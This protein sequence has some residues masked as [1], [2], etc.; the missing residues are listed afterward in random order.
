MEAKEFKKRISQLAKSIGLQ[1]NFGGWYKESSEVLSTLDLQRSNFSIKYY[2]NIKIYPQGAYGKLHTP[3]K[4]TVKENLGYN[5]F[6]RQPN[7]YNSFFDLESSISD[8]ERIIGLTSC[9]ESFINKFLERASTVQGILSLNDSGDL[10]LDPLE[11]VEF[12]NLIKQNNE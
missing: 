12:Q 7:E 8:E 5:I 6:T 10:Y 2:L 4:S 1:Y 9:F 3:S 11:I